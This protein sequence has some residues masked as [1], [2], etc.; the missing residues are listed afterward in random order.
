MNHNTDNNGV[1][2]ITQ[3]IYEWAKVRGIL[4]QSTADKQLGRLIEEAGEVAKEIRLNNVEGIIDE[5]GDMVVVV[6]NH[7]AIVKGDFYREQLDYKVDDK[8]IEVYSKFPNE[9]LDNATSNTKSHEHNYSLD[10]LHALAIAF[11]NKPLSYCLEHAYNKIKYRRGMIVNGSYVKEADFINR[12]I[13][14]DWD[15]LNDQEAE[16]ARVLFLEG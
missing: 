7:Y 10:V 12:G 15:N 4:D 8:I 16:R 9:G 3:K 1:K 14:V 6:L 11:T 5:L 2:M 13:T